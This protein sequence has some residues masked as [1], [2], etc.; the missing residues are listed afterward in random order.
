MSSKRWGIEIYHRTLKSGCKIEQRQLGNA[1]R[2]E[3]CLA[4]DM[5]IAWRIYHL[6]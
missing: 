5:V 4:I 3:S 6:T 2:I 1:D